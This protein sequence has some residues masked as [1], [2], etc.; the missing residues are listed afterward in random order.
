VQDLFQKRVPAGISVTGGAI[1]SLKDQ[2]KRAEAAARGLKKL[3]YVNSSSF[4]DSAKDLIQL[5]IKISEHARNSELQ[6]ILNAIQNEFRG[7]ALTGHARSLTEKSIDVKT[8]RGDGP[9]ME[10][11][12]ARGRNWVRLSNNTRWCTS[13]WSVSGPS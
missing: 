6:E 13:G 10:F 2:H 3:G 4:Y 5:D 12:H 8:T 1:V 9:I 7:T 11:D